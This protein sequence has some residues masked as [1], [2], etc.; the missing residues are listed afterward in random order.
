MS[1]PRCVVCGE[2]GML[3]AVG[4]FSCSACRQF[5]MAEVWCRAAMEVDPTRARAWLTAKLAELDDKGG[6]ACASD[7]VRSVS[8][9]TIRVA[10]GT[11]E[12]PA[13]VPASDVPAGAATLAQGES[14]LR[15][16][17][18]APA[19]ATQV[20]PKCQGFGRWDSAESS[21]GVIVTCPD[22]AGTGRVPRAEDA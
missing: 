19:G 13:S 3:V 4:A 17:L 16:G 12:S 6:D 20:C 9:N 11:G 1:D 21:C 14:T 2:P 8:A 18:V 15:G 7:D 10:S 22:C 5:H